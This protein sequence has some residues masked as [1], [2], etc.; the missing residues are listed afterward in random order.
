M[1]L[2]KQ[3]RPFRITKKKTHGKSKPY[4]K[5]ERDYDSNTDQE[6]DRE[7][8][9]N[10]IMPSEEES[11]MYEYRRSIKPPKVPKQEAISNISVPILQKTSIEDFEIDIQNVLQHHYHEKVG[12]FLIFIG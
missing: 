11:S 6:Y 8:R 10:G 5:Y 9:Y 1:T 7:Y 3:V 12:A 4:K 2:P